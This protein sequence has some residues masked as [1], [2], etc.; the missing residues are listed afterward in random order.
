MRLSRLSMGAAALGL[1]LG[2]AVLTTAAASATTVLTTAA[3]SATAT[4]CV[5]CSATASCI[6]VQGSGTHVNWIKG[7]AELAP[8]KNASGMV[9]KTTKTVTLS[10]NSSTAQTKWGPAVTL[11]RNL[12]N[13]DKVCATFYEL[14]PSGALTR[15][16]PACKTIK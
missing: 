2:A 10:N 4:D 12:P 5:G 16:S 8:H 7:G 6:N 11:N 14:K 3:A 9:G 1:A 15:H 13:G